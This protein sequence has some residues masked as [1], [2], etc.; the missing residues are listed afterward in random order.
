M[1]QTILFLVCLVL[2]SCDGGQEADQPIMNVRT[3]SASALAVRADGIIDRHRLYDTTKVEDFQKVKRRRLTAEVDSTGVA[4][5]AWGQE[6]FFKVNLLDRM[7]INADYYEQGSRNGHPYVLYGNNRF[8]FRMY[9]N[10]RNRF[11]FDAIIRS[12]PANGRHRIPFNI[13]T[14]G[15]RF[16]FQD[17]A[18][19]ND[20][21]HIESAPEVWNSYAVYHESRKHNGTF[22]NGSD[23]TYEKYG[24]GKAFHIYRPKVWDATGD[25]VWGFIDIDLAAGRMAV[26]VDS[27]WLH[28]P[29]RDWPVTIDPEIGEGTVGSTAYTLTNYQHYVLWAAIYAVETGAGTIDSAEIYCHV[30]TSGGTS[31]LVAHCWE[32]D[33]TVATSDWV[34]TSETKEINHTEGSKRWEPF[35]MSGTLAASTTYMAGFQPYNST[36]NRLRVWGDNANWGDI[37]WVADD[38]FVAPS[39]LTGAAETN[40]FEASLVI[41]YTVSGPPGELPFRRRRGHDRLRNN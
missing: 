20:P 34:A 24:S 33:A 19:V 27:T 21:P 15:L 12:K 23:T 10:R 14:N 22:I 4:L 29:V 13:E 11:E 1:R 25:T 17:S 9:I 16:L 5:Y 37:V 39:T 38:D 31:E 32:K 3:M 35:A 7:L 18:I 6:C 36:A 30:L 41:N 8:R 28:D 26:G 40:D 2:A